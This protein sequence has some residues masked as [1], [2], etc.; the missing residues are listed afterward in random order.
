MPAHQNWSI[1]IFLS[2]LIASAIFL[3][4]PRVVFAQVVINELLPNPT[5]GADWVELYN[6]TN[7]DINLDGW[8]LDDEG[9]KTN[10]VEIKDVTI[11][12]Y[13]FWL[14]EVGSRLNKSSDTIYL[15]DDKGLTVDEYQ[16]TANPGTDT[17]LGR[18]PDGEDWGTCSE[19]T[20]E[21]ENQCVLPTPTPT[22]SLTPTP[23]P[24]TPTPTPTPE[25]P[26]STPTL[27]PTP[28]PKAV[29]VV[30]L[31]F[32]GEILGEEEATPEAFY[33]W[34]ATAEGD[35][36]QEAT[37]SKRRILP[38]IFLGLGLTFLAAAAFSLYTKLRWP[39]QES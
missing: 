38:Y 10:M 11:S 13:T 18:M 27:S 29:E 32:S 17:S 28:T 9:T 35:V 19:A 25:P 39:K 1:K 16:Y 22:P 8:I 30:G 31:S 12:A 14:F 21:T 6:T 24:P 23:E 3:F 34:E 2:F 4:S 36:A 20:P 26:T 37:P 7:Q 5:E 33:P 15:I